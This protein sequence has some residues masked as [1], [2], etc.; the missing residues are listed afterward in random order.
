MDLAEGMGNIGDD[1]GGHLRRRQ[2]VIHKAGAN[3]AAGHA[4]IFGRCRVLGHGHTAFTLDC[5]Y[6]KCAVRTC[7]GKHYADGAF[8][9]IMGKR[10]KEEVNRQS[11]SAGSG[12]LHK[13][14]CAIEK[15]HVAIGWNDV[16]AV[17]QNLHPVFNLKD[18]HAG[19]TT[20]EVGKDAFVIRSQM[21][22]QNKGHTRIGVGRHA[23]EEGFK[24]RQATGGGAN[25]DNG[26]T[27]RGFLV[28]LLYINR[29]FF[30]G[31]FVVA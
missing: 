23:G 22:H 26:E 8:M 24:C 27:S 14:E 7:A 11:L 12:W 6:T 13:L 9:L 31:F 18:Q 28:C 20:D 25:A 16:G 2:L 30:G 21:L 19:V 3:C 1:L 4:V 17:G 29:L 10:P 5:P 15:S